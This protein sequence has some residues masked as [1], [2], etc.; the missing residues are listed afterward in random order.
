MP[1]DMRQLT[2]PQIL[3]WL[4]LLLYPFLLPLGA[5]PPHQLYP[6][7]V[8]LG[9]LQGWLWDSEDDTYGRVA[10]CQV[11]VDPLWPSLLLAI[12]LQRQFPFFQMRKLRLREVDSLIQGHTAQT[13]VQP[14]GS[15]VLLSA[16]LGTDLGWLLPHY[17]GSW[18]EI[19]IPSHQLPA[20][21]NDSNS[22]CLMGKGTARIRV[23]K[24]HLSPL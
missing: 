21:P 7:K 16:G 13:T 15:T 17:L 22:F 18:L 11:G 5:S 20:S 24:R 10:M 14:G 19:Q 2:I 1:G 6:R 8:T 12:T 3:W 4:L 9:P 23:F